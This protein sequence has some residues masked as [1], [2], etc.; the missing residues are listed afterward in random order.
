VLTEN[1]TVRDVAATIK[2]YI[3]SLKVKYVDSPIMNQLSYEVDDSKFRALGFKPMG[4]IKEGIAE[5]VRQLRGIIH[6]S[7]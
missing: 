3:P 6:S 5:E 1:L 4:N 7:R 2:K